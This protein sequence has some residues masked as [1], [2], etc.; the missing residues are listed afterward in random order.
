[1]KIK[2]HISYICVGSIGPSH[3]CSLIGGSVSVSPHG[4][5]LVGSVDFLEVSLTSWAPS[6]LCG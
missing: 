5:R 6:V 2:L 4:P 3:A 1:M